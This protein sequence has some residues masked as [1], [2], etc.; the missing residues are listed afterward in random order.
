ME[1]W[2]NI[3]VWYQLSQFLE[4]ETAKMKQSPL[5]IGIKGVRHPAL[6]LENNEKKLEF[7]TPIREEKIL[8]KV[9]KIEIF[10]ALDNLQ[11]IDALGITILRR[12]EWSSLGKSKI[13]RETSTLGRKK[14]EQNIQLN[15]YENSK[16]F[17]IIQHK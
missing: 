10:H 13:R 4:M 17:D 14:A 1:T 6:G 15:L 8:Q 16:S 2:N 5:N 7:I 9:L 3:N 11:F 12:D